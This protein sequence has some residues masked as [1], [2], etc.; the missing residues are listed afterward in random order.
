MDDQE[1]PQKS[2]LIPQALCTE[3]ALN[4]IQ[5]RYP[6]I[7]KSSDRYLLDTGSI[8]VQAKDFLMSVKSESSSTCSCPNRPFLNASA[9]LSKSRTSL[10]LS[11]IVPSSARS[12]TSTAV[13]LAPHLVPLLSAPL[14]RLKK[15]VD[16]VLPRHKSTTALEEAMW[17]EDGAGFEGAEILQSEFCDRLENPDH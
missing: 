5:R 9:R 7:Y 17:E 4:A 15:A 6:Q 2:E 8:R 10:I 14:D 11:E 1:A 16:E 3:A 12:T 13:P